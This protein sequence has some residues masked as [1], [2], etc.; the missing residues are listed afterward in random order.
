MISQNKY[1]TWSGRIL[2]VLVSALLIFSATGK[3]LKTKQV[4]DH[5]VPD[6]GYPEDVLIPLGV[7]ELSCVVLYLIPQTSV[8]GAILLTGYFGGA[9]ATH[10]RIH[11]N[12]AAPVVIGAIAWLALFLR[13]PRIRE[14]IP[15]RRSPGKAP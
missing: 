3:L 4:M 14:L 7:V 9:T 12:F 6:L 15:L 8:L 13:D 5:L 2:T 11:D 10:V 1:L